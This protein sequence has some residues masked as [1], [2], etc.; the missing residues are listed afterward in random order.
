MKKK[1]LL[2]FADLTHTGPVISSDVFPYGAGMVA[3]YLLEN[4][5]DEIEVELFKFPD[6]LA[7]ALEKR[8]PDMVGFSNYSWNFHL[9]YD[10]AE[11]IKRKYPE[12]IILFGG[13]NYGLHTKE[14]ELFWNNYNLID[15]HIVGEGEVVTG[16]LYKKLKNHSFDV[17]DLK[18]SGEVLDG[19]HY[20]YEG[21]VVRN[22]PPTRVKTLTELPS[23]YLLGLMDKFWEDRLIPLIATTRGCP[24]K[25]TMC[26]EGAAYYNKVTH[27]DNFG[28]ELDYIATRVKNTTVLSL[29]DAN[30][31]MFKRD[32]DNAKIMAKYQQSH[33]Y[34]KHL[35]TATGKNKKENVIEIAALLN[36]AMVVFASVQ[37]TD[38]EVLGKIKRSNIDIESLKGVAEASKTKDSNTV[39]EL[40]LGLPGDT[41][42]KHKKSLKD[43]VDAGLG[44]IRMYQ[45]I[46][47]KQSELN[48]PVSRDI[49]KIETLHRVMPRSFGRYQV[50][51]DEF[52]SVESEEICVSTNSMSYAD[53]LDCREMDMA[54]EILHNGS[55]FY[56]Y[57]QLCNW[58]GYSWFDF[59]MQVYEQRLRFSQKLKDL[60]S[61]FRRDNKTG[62]WK[63]YEDLKVNVVNEYD[64][65]I[66]NADGT[67]EM[68]KAKAKAFFLCSDELHGLVKEQMQLLL[69]KQ[70]VWDKSFDLYLSEL[71]RFI[72]CQKKNV[73]EYEHIYRDVFS[74][75]FI[76]LQRESGGGDPRKHRFK[77]P[78]EFEF[79]FDDNQKA[80]YGSYIN[81]YGT[82]SIDALGRL[83]M[84]TRGMN[85]VRRVRLSGD[86]VISN[87]YRELN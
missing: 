1:F 41:A 43:T 7:Q 33:G 36:G 40:I 31:G 20:L 16:S 11:R 22:A 8:K 85:M 18:S 59:L 79:Y 48:D 82:E 57:L 56:A 74:F 4:F 71:D 64:V 29:S 65:L 63:T 84:R 26:A 21:K 12:T 35:Q 45:L 52:I 19:C 24:F 58:L 78:T 30:F 51:G 13:P 75:D 23:P 15:F 60:F 32:L 50:F 80:I 62:Y 34:P 14:I 67:N 2:Y 42:E 27:N 76:S 46:L 53:H 86:S 61:Q 37:S 3:A 6:D 69:K 83:L 70:N 87:N 81:I 17:S 72:K 9:S 54:I 73:I 39:T 25:C 38:Q 44:V 49:Y 68:S 10:F 55:P 28:C 5:R 77:Q 47:L 66:N